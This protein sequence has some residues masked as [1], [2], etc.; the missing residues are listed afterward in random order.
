[1]PDALDQYID[2][3]DHLP[4]SP[5]VVVKLIALFRQVD[6]EVDEIVSIMSL[7]PSVTA[8]VLRRCNSATYA[9][10]EHVVDVFEAIMRVGFYE[11]YQ[12]AVAWFGQQAISQA[13]RSSGL[14]PDSLWRHSAITAVA[15]GQ[16]AQK[17][18][19]PAWAGFTA[20]LLHDIGKIALASAE[21]P[22]YAALTAEVGTFGPALEHGEKASFRFGHS[23]VGARLLHRWGVPQEIAAP[24]FFHHVS[25][26]PQEY[27]R[28]CAAVNLANGIAHG[29][30]RGVE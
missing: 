23:E 9:G 5:T 11:V 27:A 18:G 16:V 26:W 20:G 17:L 13:S 12:T 30:G 22:K 3:I 8:E 29:V 6:P 21:G 15:A 24:V 10:G 7:D 19:E 2:A 25:D 4:P 28:H 14:D 1:M